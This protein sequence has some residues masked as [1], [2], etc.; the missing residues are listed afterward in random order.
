MDAVEQVAAWLHRAK[1]VLVFTG[2]GIS[3]GSGIPDFRGPQGVW[4]RRQP[5][6]Y[7]EF[8]RDEGKRVEHWDFKL[9][10]W[11]GFRDARPNAAHH[12]LVTLEEM[13]RLQMLVTQNIDGLHHAAGNHP[14]RIVE[15]HG[16]NRLVECLSCGERTDPE[17]AFEA[18]KST[19]RC[20]RCHCGGLLKTAT[21]S[22][23]QD[24]KRK[25]LMLAFAAAEEADVALAI[26][27][28]LSVHPAA[29]VPLT[30]REHGARYVV[31]NQG[32]TE[33]DSVADVRLEGDAVEI[34]PAILTALRARL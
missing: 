14:D 19:R 4:Q 34:V 11:E 23:G 28:T 22:F 10:G 27:S 15:L 3:T 7:S 8:L 25:D 17:T 1:Y 12:A 20:P 29:S 31:I 30:A 16:T 13:G 2:A 21:I 9:E 24:L 6:Y 18:F 33:H 5:V 32:E 26:G